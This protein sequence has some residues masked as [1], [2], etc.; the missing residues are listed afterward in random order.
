MPA[1]D[2]DRTVGNIRVTLRQLEMFSVL[3]SHSTLSSAAAELHISES[4]L[5]QAITQVERA[6]GEHLCVRRK[7]RG[8]QLTPAGRHFAAQ[9][10]KIVRASE[11]LLLNPS[12]DRAPLRGPVHLGCFASLAPHLLPAILSEVRQRFPDIDLQLMAGT[13][14]E[15][16]PQLESGHLD[17]M[18]A[19]DLHLPGGFAKRRLYSTQL[20]AVLPQDHPLTAQ[21]TVSLADLA[22]EDLLLYGTNPSTAT[23][24]AAFEAAGLT[25]KIIMTVPQMILARELVAHGVGYTVQMSR[26]REHRLSLEGRPFAIRPIEPTAGP[27]SVVAMWPLGMQLTPRASAVLDIAAETCAS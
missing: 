10:S 25:P 1:P 11:E 15:L 17:A 7:G 2:D 18:L 20:E 24:Y 26:P 19:Y 4:A 6:A 3:P 8:L 12:Q 16:L 9:A 23:V 5:S 13:H 27:T 14:D 21:T 22:G